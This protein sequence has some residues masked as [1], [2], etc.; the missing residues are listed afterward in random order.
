MINVF[1]EGYTDIANQNH[2]N[3]FLPLPIRREAVPHNGGMSIALVTA[4]QPSG[5]ELTKLNMGGVI[6]L[7]L[8]FPQPIG[9]L[10][11]VVSA[12]DRP[13]TMDGVTNSVILAMEDFRNKVNGIVDHEEVLEMQESPLFNPVNME[14][15]SQLSVGIEKMLIIWEGMFSNDGLAADQHDDS[16]SVG[17]ADSGTAAANVS[18][19]DE[20]ADRADDS[21][22]RREGS[23]ESG[24]S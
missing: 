11:R 15:A 6:E 22:K 2:E 19:V 20:G 1:P 16:S 3:G 10:L 4:Y 14:R 13:D 17:S 12:G 24:S 7:S 21:S 9:Q 23:P 18:P 5:H 8:M